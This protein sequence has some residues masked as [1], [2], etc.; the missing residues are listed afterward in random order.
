VTTILN[1][2]QA[3]G[4]DREVYIGRAGR[5]LDGYFGNP[6]VIGHPCP[7]CGKRHE[8]RGA[9]LPCFRQYAERRLETDPEYKRRV[10]DLHGKMLVCYCFPQPCHG[11]VLADLAA[12][13][14]GGT[15]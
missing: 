1:V 15:P 3:R 4:D 10:R 2:R 5:G 8:D 7:E 6:V 14:Q 9:T 12:K 11:E 13:L